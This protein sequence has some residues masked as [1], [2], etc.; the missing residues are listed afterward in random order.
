M[1]PGSYIKLIPNQ[2]NLS[3]SEVALCHDLLGLQ[4]SFKSPES[5]PEARK[6]EPSS[7]E[8]SK[9][10]SC[11]EEDYDDY[12]YEYIAIKAK[13]GFDSM[14]D[15]DDDDEDDDISEVVT[16]GDSADSNQAG[17][18]G[19]AIDLLCG[20]VFNSMQQKPKALKPKSPISKPYTVPTWAKAKKLPTSKGRGTSSESKRLSKTKKPH[21]LVSDAQAQCQYANGNGKW[22]MSD[23][24]EPG[25]N[26]VLVGRGGKFFSFLASCLS[27][28]MS[29]APNIYIVTT[30]QVIQITTQE[31]CGGVK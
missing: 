28:L 26:D 31:M 30:T 17:E 6:Q 2:S 12:L 27:K 1:Y 20:K 3:D 15:D 7:G 22:P 11:Q 8:T 19:D 29:K 25:L 4:G 9:Q 10:S 14:Q 13:G 18:S 5:K 16:S 24:L 23:I 21:G